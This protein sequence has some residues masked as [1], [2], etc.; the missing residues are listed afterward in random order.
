[1]R[2]KHLGALLLLVVA[3][4]ATAVPRSAAASP[5]VMLS[6]GTMMNGD[7]FA[8]S[9]LAALRE[10]FAGCRHI[11][12]VLHASAPADRDRMEQRLQ[13]AFAHLLGAKAESLHHFDAAS[14]RALL[15]SADGV[16]VSGGETF[17]L[18]AELYRLQQLDVI[19]ARVAAG[20]PYLGTSAGSNVAGLL[21]G[22]TNDFPVAEIPSRQAL[23]VFPAVI[24]PHHPLP[25]DAEFK[26]RANKIGVYLK[27]NPDECVLGIGNT[28]LVRLHAGTVKV[29]VGTAWLYRA[30]GVKELHAGDAVP[31]LAE[32]AR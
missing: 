21:I 10:H 7:H 5:S 29:V 13:T 3:F 9:N 32:A 19:R 1:M 18:L 23:G 25:T 11:A 2:M 14:Q 22:T 12:L 8:D 30:S 16:F 24:N 26:G 4:A 6:G 15:E 17:V 31:E 27:F 20:I 28:S